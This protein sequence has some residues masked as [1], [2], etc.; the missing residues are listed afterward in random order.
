ME[1]LNIT[2]EKSPEKTETITSQELMEIIYKGKSLP[3]DK[4]FMPFDEGGVFKY[5]FPGTTTFGIGG[6]ERNIYYSIVNVNGEIVALGELEEDPYKEKNFWSKFTSVDP[7]FQ[8]KGYAR[9][10]IE[11]KFRFAKEKGYSIQP[12]DYT[13]EGEKLKRIFQECAKKY[14]VKLIETE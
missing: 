14:S 9:K 10:I 1:E 11:E 8:G 5:F 7:K 3:Q 13:E 2:Q 12:S 6:L 4:R